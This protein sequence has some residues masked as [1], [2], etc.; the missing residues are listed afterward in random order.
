MGL[1]NPATNVQLFYLDGKHMGN[2]LIF[3]PIYLLYR[4]FLLLFTQ[5]YHFEVNKITFYLQNKLHDQF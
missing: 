5:V 1:F 4:S 2:F 3:L